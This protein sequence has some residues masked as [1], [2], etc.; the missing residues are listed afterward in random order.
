MS[1]PITEEQREYFELYGELPSVSL[2]SY[3]VRTL[4][5][6]QAIQARRAAT[7]RALKMRQQKRTFVSSP[8]LTIETPLQKRI[9]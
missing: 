1:A 4:T 6:A 7:E 8:L 2:H 5:A 3:T 9:S